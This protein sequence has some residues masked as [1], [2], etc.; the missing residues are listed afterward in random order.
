M[1]EG[2]KRIVSGILLVLVAAIVLVLNNKIVDTCAIILLSIG[3][4]YEF[5]RVFKAKGHNPIPIVGYLSCLS[6][7]L[8]DLNIS[9]SMK[10]HI[11]GAAV[12]ILFTIMFLYIVLKDLK[13]TAVDVAVTLLSIIFVP[14]MFSFIKLIFLQPNGR[15]LILFNL[16]CSAIS[17]TMAYEVGSRIGK[18]KL[19]PVVS[20]KKSIEGSIAGIISA[21][22]SCV[23]ISLVTNT[24]FNTN[25]NII[26]IAI[27]GAILSVVGQIGDLAASSVKRYCGEK[28]FSNLIPGHG[29]ILDRF[30]SIIF[31]API[32][33]AFVY[34][35]KL[36]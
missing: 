20:P 32:L 4:I 36:V 10:I 5:N 12:P 3:G 11:I 1:K 30:D 22:V 6:I 8:L 7:I 18:H 35:F 33:Y 28:D 26:I 9:L 21:S 27:M 19:S 16:A 24:Y 14:F 29:G 2:K 31:I 13:V 23:V 34:F 17:D 25:F 15:I